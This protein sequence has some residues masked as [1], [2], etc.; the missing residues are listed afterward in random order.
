M[1]FFLLLIGC[2]EIDM[3]LG[4][5]TN[6][7]VAEG[8]VVALAKPADLDL[9]GTAYEHGGRAAAYL[10]SLEGTFPTDV[11]LSLVSDTNGTLAFGNEGEGV[12]S[13]AEGTGVSYTPGET[14]IIERDGS[15]ILRTE[16]APAASI[17]IPLTLAAGTGLHLDVG[18]EDYDGIVAVVLNVGTKEELWNNAP[19][20]AGV[21]YDMLVEAPVLDADIPG[22]TFAEPGEYAIGVAGLRV[23]EAVDVTDVNTLASLMAT[24][25]LEF[26]RMTVTAE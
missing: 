16:G 12:W 22:D 17:N 5:V 26:R 14:L 3:L 11:A 9:S 1:T 21:V 6:P 8:L 4:G 2:D 25:I 18:S 20:G 10:S 15:E 24:G 23:N 13:T 7:D 19:D